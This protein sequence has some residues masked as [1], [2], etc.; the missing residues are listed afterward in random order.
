MRE[1][2]AEGVG[3]GPPTVGGPSGPTLFDPVAAT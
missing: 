1:F 2:R 3:T